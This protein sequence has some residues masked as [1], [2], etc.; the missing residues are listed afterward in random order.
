MAAELSSW[1]VILPTS[2]QGEKKETFAGLPARARR[3]REAGTAAGGAY[4]VTAKNKVANPGDE[5][6]GLDEEERAAAE[7]EIKKGAKTGPAYCTQRKKPL[8]LIHLFEGTVVRESPEPLA[9]KGPIVSLSFCIPLTE[10]APV[11][12]QYQ[13]NAVYRKQM[14]ELSAEPDDDEK[15]LDDEGSDV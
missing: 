9:I 5:K 3:V 10:V 8:M 2:A 13:V 1:D 12:R 15:L 7:A 6:I 4:R 11:P 14:L